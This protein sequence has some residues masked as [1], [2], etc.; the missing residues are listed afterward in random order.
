MYFDVRT[1]HDQ[2]HILLREPA[3]TS[4]SWAILR[5]CNQEPCYRYVIV[6][7]LLS[8]RGAVGK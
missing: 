2:R 4:A 7:S 3:Q 1:Y 5:S 8:Q 6:P